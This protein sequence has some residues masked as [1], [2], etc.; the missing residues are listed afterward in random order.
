M[1]ACRA[2]GLPTQILRHST[3]SWVH[4]LQFSWTTYPFKNPHEVSKPLDSIPFLQRSRENVMNTADGREIHSLLQTLKILFTSHHAL[5][6]PIFSFVNGIILKVEWYPGVKKSITMR[7]TAECSS[8][9]HHWTSGKV[10]LSCMPLFLSFCNTPH[11]WWTASYHYSCNPQRLFF[12]QHLSQSPS[13][14]IVTDTGLLQFSSCYFHTPLAITHFILAA[15]RDVILADMKLMSVDKSLM[16]LVSQTGD[17][18]GCPELTCTCYQTWL[19]QSTCCLSPPCSS[20]SLQT[21]P[22]RTSP[23]HV[24][25]RHS[26]WIPVSQTINCMMANLLQNGYS[27]HAFSLSTLFTSSG[28]RLRHDL[29][30]VSIST[31]LPSV[32][33]PRS[34]SPRLHIWLSSSSSAFRSSLK[35]LGQGEVNSLL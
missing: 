9:S 31:P 32:Y 22:R 18:C 24:T 30:T 14:I 29:L 8:S 1:F 6:A 23:D 16:M 34:S 12:T 11:K 33:G 19:L 26:D 3:N 35:G 25:L 17:E 20:P 7:V 21:L 13:D 27:L 5:L 2:R 10:L 28:P 15:P 4:L